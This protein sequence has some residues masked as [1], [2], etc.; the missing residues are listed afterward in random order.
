MFLGMLPTPDH[1]QRE[2]RPIFDGQ[3]ASGTLGNEAG[4]H[5]RQSGR[6]L[7]GKLL[8]QVDPITACIEVPEVARSRKAAHRSR[9]LRRFE[10][11]TGDLRSHL[12][13]RAPPC[14]KL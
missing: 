4:M 1:L 14:R 7:R 6:Y 13:N 11:S 3:T 8:D 5:T 10:I 2:E 12:R 9:M